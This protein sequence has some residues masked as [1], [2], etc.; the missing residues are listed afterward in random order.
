MKKVWLLRVLAGIWLAVL[1]RITVFRNGCFS[2]GLFSG[3]I[4][5]DAFAYYSKLFR[6]R[7][8]SEGHGISVARSGHHG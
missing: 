2:H 6:T 7:C 4:E 3:R 5:W 8:H 1:L